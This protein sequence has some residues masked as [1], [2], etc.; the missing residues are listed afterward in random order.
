MTPADLDAIRERDA[1]A[2]VSPFQPQAEIDR[3]ALLSHVYEQ[4]KQRALDVEEMRRL[5][6]ERDSAREALRVSEQH[7]RELSGREFVVYRNCGKHL[8]V[9]WG[10]MTL[11]PGE[12]PREVCP[13]CEPPK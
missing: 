10:D 9:P 4:A 11:P 12:Q 7:V 1:R 8:S 3:R 5:A 6:L 13:I 2:P